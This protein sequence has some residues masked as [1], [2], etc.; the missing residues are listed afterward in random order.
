M[1]EARQFL[2]EWQNDPLGAKPVF[3]EYMDYLERT[4][5]V[6]I[7]W[8]ARPGVSYSL[9][10]RHENQK[11]RPLFAVIDVVDDEPENR[12][13]SACFFADMVSDPDETGDLAPK[14]LYD[15]DALC[16]NLDEDDPRVARYIFDR[17]KEA[18]EKAAR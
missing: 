10:A 16:F 5:G 8:L 11:D 13:I 4:P 3:A 18:A 2:K 6:E 12:W 17:V 14:G 1:S 9:R 15:E 7:S